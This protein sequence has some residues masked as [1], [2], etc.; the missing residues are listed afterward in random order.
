MGF[1]RF[2]GLV[3]FVGLLFLTACASVPDVLPDSF[4]AK[5]SSNKGL[6]WKIEPPGVEPS[7]LFGT[8]HSEDP[9]VLDL[10][11]VVLHS[12]NHSSTLALEI[13]LSTQS[14]QYALASMF[15]SDGRTLDEVVGKSLAE[16]AIRAMAGRGLPDHQVMMMKPWAIF[17]M[18]NM[19]ASESGVYLDL[20]LHKLATAQ[21]KQ[22]LGLET[23][24]EQIATFDQM[25]MSDQTA[26]LEHSLTNEHTLSE[27]LD[28]TI[29]IYLSRDLS[30][31]EELNESYMAEMPAELA[32]RFT[33]RLIDYRNLRM[34]ERMKPLLKSGGAFIAVGALHLPGE[35]G[36]INQIRKEGIP[37]SAS[38]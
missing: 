35:S 8:I 36:L 21:G 7:Y 28:K 2:R 26:L 12:F 31:M 23:I 1:S 37:L 22:I 33:Y 30:A 25:S 5:G 24:E 19:P 14:S 29:D 27:L 38:Y 6:L 20:K 9:R 10:P 32:E 4:S 13:E 17:T 11:Q 34:Y 16:K 15:F 18:V 3:F